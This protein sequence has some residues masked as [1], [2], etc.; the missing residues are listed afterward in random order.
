MRSPLAADFFCTYRARAVSD[1]DDTPPSST[2]SRRLDTVV[3]LL[4]VVP[5]HIVAM[6]NNKA[7]VAA[8]NHRAIIAPAN[9]VEFLL[10]IFIPNLHWLIDI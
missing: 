6:H 9:F 2:C 5:Q 10:N 3:L 8:T 7:T 1:V 4:L